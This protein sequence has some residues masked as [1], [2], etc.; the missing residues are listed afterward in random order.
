MSAT[1]LVVEDEASL[2]ET[3][4][5][6]LQQQGY[7]ILTARDGYTAIELSRSHK[8]DL[9]LLDIMLPGLDGFEVCRLLRQEI[10]TPIIMLTAR[11]DEIDQIVGLELGADDYL[12][13]PFSMRALLARVRAHLRRE[14]LLYEEVQASNHQTPLPSAPAGNVLIFGDLSI[15]VDAREV[16]CRGE[17]VHLKP[18]EFDLLVFLARNHGRVLSRDELLAEV[19]GWHD[20]GDSRTVDVHIRW[21]RE[22]IEQNP[23]TPTRI[24]TIRSI[25]YRFEG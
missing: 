11:T 19:W 13:K 12:T 9:I 7:Q 22:K 2:L 3:I 5:Y 25:G 18:M 4:E 1:V 10:R 20:A 17:P 21:L 8:L 23:G 6:N 24:V 16:I 15:N 14:R